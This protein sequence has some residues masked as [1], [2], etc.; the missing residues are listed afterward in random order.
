MPKIY[1]IINNCQKLH[2]YLITCL[3]SIAIFSPFYFAGILQSGSKIKGF[4]K[5]QNIQMSFFLLDANLTVEIKIES[6]L[7]YI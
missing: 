7:F 6:V 1:S 2:L 5:S 3:E 4:L